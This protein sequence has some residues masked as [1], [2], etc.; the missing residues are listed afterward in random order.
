MLDAG[1]F[2]R[3]RLFHFSLAPVLVVAVSAGTDVAEGIASSL[4]FEC[5]HHIIRLIRHHLTLDLA[6]HD[7]ARKELPPEASEDPL[8]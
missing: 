6:Q 5:Q 3:R 7:F 1:G 8:H 4:S 2:F